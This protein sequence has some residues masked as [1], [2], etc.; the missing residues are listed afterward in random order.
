M[1]RYRSWARTGLAPPPAVGED[2]A[3][4][5]S[6]LQQW[7]HHLHITLAPMDYLRG[8]ICGRGA[9]SLGT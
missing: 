4:L 9:F 6:K 8:L 3:G 2:H 1:D 5:H 7:L